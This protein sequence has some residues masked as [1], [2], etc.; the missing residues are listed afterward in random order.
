MD[1]SRILGYMEN[2]KCHPKKL[3]DDTV[4]E[5]VTAQHTRKSGCMLCQSNLFIEDSNLRSH[6]RVVMNT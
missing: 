2:P 1:C 4:L 6:P 3:N 5:T